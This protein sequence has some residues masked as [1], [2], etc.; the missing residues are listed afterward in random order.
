MKGE[1]GQ[2]G[3]DGLPGVKGE[4]GLPGEAGVIGK[5]LPTSPYS[6]KIAQKSIDHRGLDDKLHNLCCVYNY[7]DITQ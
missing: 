1:P 2:R 6:D 5:N 3:F 7:Y 4:R